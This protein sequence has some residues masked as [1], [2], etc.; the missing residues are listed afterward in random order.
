MAVDTKNH[1]TVILLLDTL[2]LSNDKNGGP[3]FML[4]DSDVRIY[5]FH[6]YVVTFETMGHKHGAH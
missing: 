5:R 6:S 1:D 3:L 2:R 4:I